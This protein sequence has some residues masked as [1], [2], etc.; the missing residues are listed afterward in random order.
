MAY[1]YPFRRSAA[2]EYDACCNI[3]SCHSVLHALFREIADA[4]QQQ[5]TGKSV[6][7]I[8]VLDQMQNLSQWN[9]SW[10]RFQAANG[11]QRLTALLQLLKSRRP[12]WEL[13][14]WPASLVFLDGI[15]R[16]EVH[17]YYEINHSAKQVVITKFVGLPP[18]P[19]VDDV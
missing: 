10:R 19:S 12:P 6:D 18:G 2:A 13:R 11:L 9:Y 4:A 1:S 17:I 3:Y 5:D 7:A 15:F 8:E 16:R 14:M